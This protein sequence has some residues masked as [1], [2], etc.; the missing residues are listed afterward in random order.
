[1][2]QSTFNKTPENCADFMTMA[3]KELEALFS[4]VRELFG[5]KQAQLSAEDWLKELEVINTLPTTTREWRRITINVAT[6]LAGRMNGSVV[7]S[8]PL[9][10]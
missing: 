7:P 1:M 4:A 10:T 6:R 3:E 2:N 9:V 8:S 5:V